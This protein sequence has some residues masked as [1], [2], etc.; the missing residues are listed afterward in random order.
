MN[1]RSIFRIIGKVL[2]VEAVFML[3]ALVISIGLQEWGAVR[4]IAITMAAAGMI[5]Y[6]LNR[7]PGKRPD[8]YARDGLVT[9]GAAWLAVSL[10]GALPFWLSG[11]IP[12]Y[13]DC[14][15]ET[16]SGFTTT[17]ATILAEIES[18]PH[19]LLYWRSFTHWLGGM[20]ML[21]FLL[22]LNPLAQK[23]SGEN[24]HLLRAE[25]PGVRASKLVPRMR[26]SASIL[27]LIYIA[28]TLLEFLLL[29]IG[30]VPVFDSLTLA[31]GTAGTGGFT[32]RNDSAASYSAYAQ[33]ILII[34]MFLFSVNFNIYFLI[35]LRQIKKAFQNSELRTFT[36][37]F[38]V[39]TLL[40]WASTRHYWSNAE[41]GLRTSA[42]QVVSIMSTTGFVSTDFDLWPEFSRALIVL[43]MFV[44]ACA[45]ST[46]GGM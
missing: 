7:T 32:I 8:I 15:F 4:G 14:L 23:D 12:N 46:G 33:W 5:G 41:E 45:G 43:L 35:L 3:P 34:F 13:F 44:G 29:L 31:F 17:G 30:K 22:A 40:I 26:E 18:L 20:G 1:Y 38:C 27:Y 9:V 19:G 10:V 6:P 36:L 24:M 42:F 25:S 21:V 28:L 39:G 11:A 2:W 16:A 37:L